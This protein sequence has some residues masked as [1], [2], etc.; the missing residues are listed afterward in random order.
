MQGSRVVGQLAR[1]RP[2]LIDRWSV[3]QGINKYNVLHID[4]SQT[5]FLPFCLKKL[6]EVD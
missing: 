2:Y 5:G 6:D 3:P 1:E 4:D